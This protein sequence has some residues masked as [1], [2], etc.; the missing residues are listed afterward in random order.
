[1]PPAFRTTLQPVVKRADADGD[2][3]ETGETSGIDYDGV[4]FIS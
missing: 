1:M 3:G 4:S 2:T